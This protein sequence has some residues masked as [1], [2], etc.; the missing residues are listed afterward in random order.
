MP[1]QTPLA[2]V[3]VPRTPST[4]HRDKGAQNSIPAPLLAWPPRRQPA[5]QP[6]GVRQHIYASSH[7]AAHKMLCEACLWKEHSAKLRLVRDAGDRKQVGE[8]VARTH[9]ATWCCKRLAS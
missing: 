5:R 3:P 1:T 4:R 9:W 7:R 6:S 2:R 8:E